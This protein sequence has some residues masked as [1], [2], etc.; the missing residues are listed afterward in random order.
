M[1]VAF[2][3]TVAREGN[4]RYVLGNGSAFG[5]LSA[6]GAGGALVP[7]SAWATDGVGVGAGALDGCRVAHASVVAPST[8][9]RVALM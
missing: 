5:R 4:G 1:I 7:V 9:G 3:M 8:R 6:A 2:L